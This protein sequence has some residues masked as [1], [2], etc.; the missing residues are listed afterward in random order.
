MKALNQKIISP[1][2]IKISGALWFI[3][4]LLLDN[5]NDV[6]MKYVGSNISVYE[7]VFFRFMFSSLVLL[8]F[9]VKRDGLQVTRKMLFIHFLRGAILFAGIALWCIGLS[10]TQISVAT[11]INFIIP[12][13]IL[14][15]S[16]V[17]LKEKFSVVKSIATFAGFL[18][19]II[20]INPTGHDF[21]TTSLVLIVSA[22][23]FAILDVINKWIVHSESSINMMFY[24][25]IVVFALAIFPAY[26][27]WVTP[28]AEDF[29][30]LLILG[31]TCNLIL[32]CLLKSFE[33]MEISAVAPYRY[34]EIFFSVSMGYLV[35]GEVPKYTTI[36]GA[37]IIISATFLLVYETFS[38]KKQNV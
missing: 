13:Y 4:S 12:I 20:V 15:L 1:Q 22:L 33:V 26:K 14:V 10:V 7:V 27:N 21:N 8:P 25:G 5:I 16:T 35:F 30:L 11:A 18:G 6:I 24:S 31:C 19:T 28:S 17:F 37:V 3:A 32:Y 36:A 2:T 9:I 23:L 29:V 38:H 34:T